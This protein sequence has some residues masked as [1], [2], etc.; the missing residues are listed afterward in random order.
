MNKELLKKCGF[1]VEVERIENG[2]CPFCCLLVDEAD[3][4]DELSKKEFKLS[5]MCS[6]CQDKFFK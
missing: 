1:K 6:S 4:K 3:F 5:G 2:K